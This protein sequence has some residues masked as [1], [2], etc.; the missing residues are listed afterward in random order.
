MTNKKTETLKFDHSVLAYM[1][2]A[3]LAVEKLRVSTEVGLAH[4]AKQGRQDPE[5]AEVLRRVVPIEEY[6]DVRVGI[7]VQSH[8]AYPWFSLVSGV[9]R[10]NIGK[11]VA[12]IRVKLADYLVCPECHLRYDKEMGL[13]AC[14]ECGD[15]LLEPP[16]ADT[17]SALWKFAGFAPDE[18]G[19]AM[20]PVRGGGKLAYNSRLRSMSW[21]LGS[22][23]LKAG[24]RKQCVNCNLLVGEQKI[25]K[26]KGKCPDCG[27]ID[28]KAV[29]ITGFPKYY[30]KE[31]DNYYQ[32]SGRMGIA[33][34][35]AASLP[36]DKKGKRYE[37]EGMI[38]EGHVHNQAMR[39]MI[40][41]FLACLWLVWREAEGL[42]LTKPYA[43]DKLGHDSYI[44]PWEMTDR[45]AGKKE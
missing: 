30:L 39:K 37:P 10:E 14:P 3:Q 36:K 2:D 11:V 8:P 7:L 17:I 35:P 12:P 31:K 33:I 25:K 26:N 23:L 20:R 1:V 24:L 13:E 27:C 19:K 4:L 45:E 42:P 28:F 29:A 40:K 41:L 34:V 5:R 22:S 21:R 15:T 38:S 32:R 9:G 18:E 44:D 43:L 6:L 16:F